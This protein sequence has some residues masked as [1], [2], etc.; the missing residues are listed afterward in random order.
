VQNRIF[1]AISIYTYILK[2]V[3]IYIRKLN[4]ER[5][6][7]FILLFLLPAHL[8]IADVIFITNK[9]TSQD[10]HVYDASGGTGPGT[11]ADTA[12]DDIRVGEGTTAQNRV[13]Y[14]LIGF[15][16]NAIAGST[17]TAATLYINYEGFS[18]T[19]SDICSLLHF[20]GGDFGSTIEASDFENFTV[21]QND[22]A[23]LSTSG[24]AGW[25]RIDVTTAVNY[26]ANNAKAWTLNS[27][28]YWVQF[29]IRPDCHKLDD[30][31]GDYQRIN[32]YDNG[33]LYPYLVVYYTPPSGTEININL[34]KTETYN[35]HRAENDIPV[36]SVEIT[37][38]NASH[39][40]TCFKIKNAGTAQNTDITEVK[41]WA[42]AGTIGVLDNDS[43]IATL[44]WNN[45]YGGWTN[46]NLNVN[47][48][49]Y[50]VTVSVSASAVFNRTFQAKIPVGGIICSGGATNESSVSNSQAQTIISN[51]G[52]GD[53]VINEIM[54]M[55]SSYSNNSYDEW[56]ELRNMTGLDINF[57]A[58]PFSI[59][60]GDG[61]KF[62]TIDHGILEAG[63]Y[64]L[65][66]NKSP[67]DPKCALAVNPDIVKGAGVTIPNSP[68]CQLI[69]YNTLDN[70]G[71]VIDTAGDNSANWL[72]GD[73]TNPPRKA[74]VR[75]EDPGDGT[76]GA[77]WYTA[78][79][80]IGWKTDA[81][82]DYGTPGL[83]NIPDLTS[84]AAITN[85]TAATTN[86]NGGVVLH[87]TAPGDDG[88]SG[89]VSGY[90]V[91]YS[92]FP[93]NTTNDWD[94]AYNYDGAGQW[95]NFVPGGSDETRIVAY[96]PARTAYYF[97]VRA[98]D[99]GGNLS[100]LGNSAMATTWYDYEA[101]AAITNLKVI[102]NY[103]AGQIAITFTAPGDDGWRGTANHYI[104]KWSTNAINNDT[105]FS[106]AN[107]YAQSWT[108]PVGGSDEMYV[109]SGLPG[110]K[111]IYVAIKVVDEAGNTSGLSNPAS[112][113]AG[114]TD[115]P[116][117]LSAT[118]A[119]DSGGGI[120]IQAG[121]TVTI[122]FNESTGAPVINA[123]N[124]DTVLQLSSGHTWLDGTGSI[125]NAYWTTTTYSNDTLVIVLS[126]NGGAPT[127]AVG[128]TVTADGI[129]ISDIMGNACSDSTNITGTFG[130]DINPPTFVSAIAYDTGGAAGLNPGDSV[131]I[132][133]SETMDT[134]TLTTII[135]NIDS[136]LRLAGGTHSWGQVDAQWSSTTYPYDTLT[137]TIT[138]TN[139]A[140]IAIGDNIDNNKADTLQDDGPSFNDVTGNITLT[141][142]FGG[143]TTGPAMVSAIAN[144]ASG[145]GP[146]IQAGDQVII[147][148]DEETTG[149]PIT[150]ANINSVLQLSGGHSWLD[151]SGNIGSAVWTTNIYPNDTLIITLSDAVSAPTVAVGDVITIAANT[152]EDLAGNDAT[153]GTITG[154]FGDNGYGSCSVTPNSVSAGSVNMLRF[155]ITGETGYVITTN[156]IEIDTNWSW[157]GDPADIT[158]YGP[159]YN[160]TGCTLYIITNAPGKYTIK[161]VG[162]QITPTASGYIEIYNMT[163]PT[164]PQTTYFYT[165]TATSNTTLQYI[166]TQPY[167]IV[168]APA[169]WWNAYFNK[170][171]YR[172]DLP[173]ILVNKINEAKYK[174]DACIYRL[175]VSSVKN[176]LKAAADRGVE[177][178]IIT[179]SD[180]LGDI[181]ALDGYAGK[182][183]VIDETWGSPDSTGSWHMHNKFWIFDFGY[184][185]DD[186][187]VEDVVWSGSYNVTVQA[188][189]TD[190]NYQANNVIEIKDH[191]LASNFWVEFNEMWGSST[192]T[193]N[194]A[195][196]KFSTSKIDNT[197]HIFSIGGVAS[198]VEL[199]F[200]PDD[201]VK[202][203]IIDAMNTANYNIYFC[204]FTFTDDDIGNLMIS[205]YNSGIK[206]Q[207]V[208]DAQQ[209]GISGSEYDKLRNA[210]GTN[211]IHNKKYGFTTLLHHKYMIID[212][213]HPESDPIVI[214]GSYNWTSSAE[215]NNDENCLIIHDANVTSK[216]YQEFLKRFGVVQIVPATAT[217]ST[218]PS[219]IIRN[220]VGNQITITITHDG[221]V[222]DVI[223]NVKVVVPSTWPSIVNNGNTTAIRGDGYNYSANG[224]VIFTPVAG[225]TEIQIIN[226]GIQP[227]GTANKVTITID[228]MT[229][230]ATAGPSSFYTYVSTANVQD[231]QVSPT[232]KVMVKKCALII[233]E[234]AFQGGGG[235]PPFDS[236]DWVEVYCA[237]DG[238]NGDGVDLNGFYFTT[239]DGGP[240]KTISSATLH[241]GK[242]AVLL[243]NNSTPDETT[244]G[245][246]V[247]N[248]Y[249]TAAGLTGTDE[250]IDIYDDTGMLL[251]AVCWA[252][253]N[254]SWTTGEDSDVQYIAGKNEWVLATGTPQESDCVDSSVV[255][256][257]VSI[258]RLFGGSV[259]PAGYLDS[260]KKSDWAIDTSPTPGQDNSATGGGG[261]ANPGDV[262][263]NEIM[264]DPATSDTYCEWIELYNTRPYNIDLSGWK[265]IIDGNTNTISSGTISGN[266]YFVIVARLTNTTGDSFEKDFG[267]GN[268]NWGDDA[269]YE[270]YTP[271]VKGT[272]LGIVNTGT[273]I[274]INDGANDIDSVTFDPAWGGAP[275]SGITN[276]S[277]E[278]KDPFAP[279]NDGNNWGS[280]VT[281]WTPYQPHQGTPG[282]QNSLAGGNNKYICINEV[283][284]EDNDYPDRDEWIE[285]YNSSAS[286]NVSL[287]GWTLTDYDGNVYTFPIG[288]VIPPQKF[289]VVHFNQ[290][291]DDLDFTDGKGDVFTGDTTDILDD[292][293]ELGLYSGATRNSTTI[294]D[295][296]AWSSN[297]TIVDTTADN[298]AV[299]ASNKNYAYWQDD[300]AVDVDSNPDLNLGRTIYL[301]QDGV[302]TN[303]VFDWAFS[304]ST[305]ARF[306]FSEGY[307]NIS[308]D[309]NVQ[310]NISN[311]SIYSSQ[312][313]PSGDTVRIGEQFYIR[314]TTSSD[315][316]P[317]QKTVTTVRVTSSSNDKINGIV[318]TLVETGAN[319]GIFEGWVKVDA[320]ES[321]DPLQWIK[322]GTL[323]IIKVWWSGDENYFDT[324]QV[325]GS[326]AEDIVINEFVPNPKGTPDNGVTNSH[327]DDEWIEIYNR[328]I[329]SHNLG[330][331]TIRFDNG[332]SYR[333]PTTVDGNSTVLA[334][335]SIST[336]WIFICPF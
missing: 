252:N 263:I 336:R 319:T 128:D 282:S 148:F 2:S 258:C 134:N 254:G 198:N 174:I 215:N 296:V 152:I 74:M 62:V 320:G 241:T 303:G 244:D 73:N 293:D 18:G 65:I 313:D 166:S 173:A 301:I 195:N 265:Y 216:F 165:K 179:E 139:G 286:A 321:N 278:R 13:Y 212:V 277:L 262:V 114:E 203:K 151:G 266:G 260:N 227:S 261:T 228:N 112:G 41:L 109:M 181:S 92:F 34:N 233:T 316:S 141:G 66:A 3:I 310:K 255:G 280:C 217:I 5:L 158:N 43:L 111:I 322:A 184:P 268:N 251:D 271:Y 176:A 53:V 240:I 77:N 17:V 315:P 124:I 16:V 256:A 309:T 38:T 104:V 209:S 12:L 328:G 223:T 99:E 14:G 267:N 61:T 129:T 178:R 20:D 137:I 231:G 102:S 314:L 110:N 105:D 48:T 155:T 100:P 300:Q 333:I 302:S 49:N 264:Y 298:D 162:A 80:Q 275:L 59:Y 192:L 180:N 292:N 156:T 11:G 202:A 44:Y 247:L 318:V 327:M 291:T 299:A 224:Q 75:K 9:T 289:L 29:R 30:S 311:L 6:A 210:I 52:S 196:A 93:I 221:T 170:S 95:Y 329:I 171:P 232:P 27:S 297:G 207:G 235:D 4:F 205:K 121:D 175:S 169:N 57:F 285:I 287:A 248:L 126:T 160:V 154:S 204:I 82:N 58:T 326:S 10:G 55:G 208:F 150:A 21:Y 238:N 312:S 88:W 324:I 270:V 51:F 130:A 25:R 56:V 242:Y 35:L 31:T 15:N 67:S 323:E 332:K 36:L 86:T 1:S 98:Y 64:F 335:N 122:I 40:F 214:V 117:I 294:V 68:N 115:P 284:F 220:S 225:G 190:D 116:I 145:G 94:N 106:N 87:W 146:G 330:N 123:A 50:I 274:I 290:G 144:D 118:A 177:I 120:G 279:S 149:Y 246:A 186:S 307:S 79:N 187:T 243:F 60:R 78:T 63:G 46:G 140:T 273:T 193:P 19:Q 185:G 7:L 194:N 24:V 219:F 32:S 281:R 42:D 108:P 276:V 54:W 103:G 222:N 76:V 69:L 226:A 136:V 159:G 47:V 334:P 206:V 199:Y 22:F 138:N 84:P 211:N 131:V 269:T 213:G 157:T 183:R 119:D 239:E 249:T 83:A 250:Q 331:W 81:T 96:L 85:L 70:S 33:S 306:F 295:F 237:D 133:F 39:T 26:A 229:A 167:V 172:D 90:I 197:Q 37:D 161:V 135:S 107:T 72:A 201:G 113:K 164:V 45:T 89:T 163:A 153:G 182:I 143:D 188:G 125:S 8:S 189:T 305:N 127:V 71:T 325:A 28:S 91:R 147:T 317:G 132:Q 101:P 257:G 236:A 168:T 253:Q 283:Y 259:G 288:C 234:V 200:S 191:T 23:T 142:T 97:S 308:S 272:S 218:V 245:G 304:S 230:P